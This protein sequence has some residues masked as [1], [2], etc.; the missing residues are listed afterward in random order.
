MHNGQEKD[1][2]AWQRQIR[3]SRNVLDG[4]KATWLDWEVFLHL[5]VRS[6]GCCCCWPFQ[7]EIDGADKWNIVE[8][9]GGGSTTTTTNTTDSTQ[10]LEVYKVSSRMSWLNP[11]FEFINLSSSW[12]NFK[13]A[14]CQNHEYYIFFKNELNTIWPTKIMLLTTPFPNIRG[15]K[16]V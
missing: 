10:N 7:K 3:V 11:R 14:F 13:M 16:K 2:L 9:K 12:W 5:L 4:K 1:C 15:S 8:A 6:P